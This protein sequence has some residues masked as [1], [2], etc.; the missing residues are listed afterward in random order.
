ME[1]IAEGVPKSLHGELYKSLVSIVLGTRDKDAIPTELAKKI[2]YL[3]RQDQ[4]ASKTGITA[5][6]EAAIMVDAEATHR[7]L[8]ELGLQELAVAL[9]RLE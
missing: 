6:L 8:D 4:L 3:W 7:I 5:M 1:T 9:K 2:I